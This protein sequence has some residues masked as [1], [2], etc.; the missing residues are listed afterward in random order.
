M[1]VTKLI[2]L[3]SYLANSRINLFIFPLANHTKTIPRYDDDSG[4][5]HPSTTR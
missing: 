1:I 5:D 3:V 2:Y 4:E